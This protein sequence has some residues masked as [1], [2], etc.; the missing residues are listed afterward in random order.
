MARA[1]KIIID[2]KRKWVKMDMGRTS[3]MI[4]K[5]IDERVDKGVIDADTELI[6]RTVAYQTKETESLINQ[7]KSMKK[8]VDFLKYKINKLEDL[9]NGTSI[10]EQ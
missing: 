9:I 7:I 2:G 6:C 1:P 10:N 5:V 4:M 3:K 8:N